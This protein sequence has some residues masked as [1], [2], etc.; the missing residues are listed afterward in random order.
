MHALRHTGI[1]WERLCVIYLGLAAVLVIVTV[2]ALNVEFSS[3]AHVPN[4]PILGAS[5]FWDA[6]SFGPR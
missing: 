2:L 3:A 6:W 4:Y 1:N 5:D